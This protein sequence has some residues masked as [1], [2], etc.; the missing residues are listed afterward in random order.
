ML[1]SFN[2]S[3]GDFFIQLKGNNAG[4]VLKQKSPNSTGIVVNRSFLNPDYAY[5]L[6]YTIFLTGCYKNFVKGSVIPYIRIDDI[7]SAFV[8]FYKS[9]KGQ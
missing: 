4:Q 5:W 8:E 6:F 1:F 3:Y 9:K 2:P 7:N